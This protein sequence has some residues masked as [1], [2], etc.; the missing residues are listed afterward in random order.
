MSIVFKTLDR[1]EENIQ[2]DYKLET[3][4][5]SDQGFHYT[6]SDFQLP[7]KELGLIQS[8]S[9]KG[10]CLDNA[11]M[12]SFFWHMKDEM[13]YSESLLFNELELIVDDY[14]NYY[15]RFRYQLEL[16]KM[17]PDQYRTHILVA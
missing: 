5:H 17:S 6:N 13:E 1:L 9:L 8:M 4:I 16:N 14:M 2:M 15:N 10:N 12:E 11:P 7:V 3:I